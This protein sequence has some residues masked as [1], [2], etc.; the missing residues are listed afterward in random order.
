MLVRF[1][2][3]RIISADAKK[4]ILRK[5]NIFKLYVRLVH[6]LTERHLPD[7]GAHLDHAVFILAPD[8][9]GTQAEFKIR[10]LI[11]KDGVLILVG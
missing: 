5:R 7:I 6:D 10:H 9:A 1:H 2:Q 11:Q 3:R 8:L 4:I